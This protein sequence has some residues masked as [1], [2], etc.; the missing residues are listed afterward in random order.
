MLCLQRETHG[1]DIPWEQN[2]LSVKCW[3]K[4]A[5][6]LLGSIQGIDYMMVV[7]KREQVLL[8]KYS[9]IVRF[10]TYKWLTGMHET[11]LRTLS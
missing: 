4:E 8:V 5:M 1:K 11:L 7:A 3:R 10:Q 6:L 9:K 2:K